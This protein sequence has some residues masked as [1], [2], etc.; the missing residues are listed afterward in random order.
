MIPLYERAGGTT[1]YEKE[2]GSGD[3]G[4][5]KPALYGEV[6]LPCKV[7]QPAWGNPQPHSVVC[8]QEADIFYGIRLFV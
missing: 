7:Q 2:K 5:R 1:A 8:F 3:S 4:V 6:K